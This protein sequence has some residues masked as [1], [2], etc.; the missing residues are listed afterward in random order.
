MVNAHGVYAK[1]KGIKFYNLGWYNQFDNVSKHIG[2]KTSHGHL[3]TELKNGKYVHILTPYPKDPK[4]RAMHSEEYFLEADNNQQPKKYKAD[5]K[6]IAKGTAWDTSLMVGAKAGYDKLVSGG[7]M[8]LSRY[9]IAAAAVAIIMHSTKD[10]LIRHKK[11]HEKAVRALEIAARKLRKD[12]EFRNKI[13]ELVAKKKAKRR[14]IREEVLNEVAAP[15]TEEWVLNNKA[16]FKKRYG[17]EWEK[18]L[19][20]HAWNMKKAHKG[21]LP[22]SF[23]QHNEGKTLNE[24]LGFRSKKKKSKKPFD[25]RAHRLKMAKMR[26]Q[27]EKHRHNAMAQRIRMADSIYKMAKSQVTG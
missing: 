5:R 20:A 15:G 27:V 17:K 25:I 11:Y 12:I 10:Y 22:K 6:D 3:H 7:N 24:V 4:F 2:S 13:E 26:S 14:G 18:Y 21:K 16:R 8:V 23:G 1:S 9:A 19:Y